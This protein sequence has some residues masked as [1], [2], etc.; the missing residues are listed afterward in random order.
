[1]DPTYESS[2][3]ESNHS[4][5]KSV[6][7]KKRRIDASSISPMENVSSG[8]VGAAA[9]EALTSGKKS[10]SLELLQDDYRYETPSIKE[11]WSEAA[12]FILRGDL[13]LALKLIE[14]LPHPQGALPTPLSPQ[15]YPAA[16]ALAC[17]GRTDGLSAFLDKGI[18]LQIGDQQDS[19]LIIAIQNRQGLCAQWLLEKEPSL[20]D[21]PSVANGRLPIS[22][23]VHSGAYDVVIQL[24]KITDPFII[25]PN[26]SD[27]F[28]SIARGGSLPAMRHF[29]SRLSKEQTR[30]VLSQKDSSGSSG[31]MVVLES[32]SNDVL[33]G[34]I[35]RAIK[36]DG[37]KEDR[38][39]KGE[40]GLHVLFRRV[41][42][43]LLNPGRKNGLS[44]ALAK[45]CAEKFFEAGFD[46]NAVSKDGRLPLTDLL[47]PFVLQAYLDT[48]KD[49]VELVSIVL[50]A[51]ADPDLE[52][53][54]NHSG[55]SYIKASKG[56]CS[57]LL[58]AALEAFDIDAATQ[59]IANLPFDDDLK[60]TA[61]KK[62]TSR[63]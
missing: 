20:S 15:M 36:C 35:D 27:A 2:G 51:G 38:N 28:K 17:I 45:T 1:M 56:V 33:D 29:L 4:E 55:R 61:F 57:S 40:S 44:I 39:H 37:L 53:T 32:S 19:L 11:Q 14:E 3:T 62:P 41:I 23:A 12:E 8:V 50:K 10:G 49:I 7:L 34:I 47:E 22:E 5:P 48:P 42:H 16:K 30:L 52:S 6:P 25:G 24:S 46:P 13:R 9:L 31:L 43:S 54:K 58:K 59:S 60:G 21:I 63:L 18:S 26:G